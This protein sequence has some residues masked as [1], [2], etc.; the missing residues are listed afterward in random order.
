MLAL[1]QTRVTGQ[2]LVRNVRASAID[3]CAAARSKQSGSEPTAIFSRTAISAGE[4]F[5]D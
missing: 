3:L 2:A 4:R 5:V 1:E